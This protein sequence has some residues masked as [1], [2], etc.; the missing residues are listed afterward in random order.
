MN[1]FFRT[2]HLVLG[3]AAG[4]VIALLCFTGAMLAFEKELH[5]LLYPERYYVQESGA[6]R[7]ERAPLDRLAEELRRT[8]P[9]AK[10]ASIK[11]YSDP[12]RTAEVGYGKGRGDNRQAFMNPYSGEVVALGASRAPFFDMMFSLHR[13]LVAGDIGKM[14]VGTSSVIFLFI[15]ATGIVLWWPKSRAILRQ[16]LRLKWDGGW[17]RLTH[18][19]HV[20]IGSYAAI[21]LFICAFTGLAWS[22][23]W[24]NNGI[25]W[26]TGTERPKP[27][28]SKAQKDTTSERKA[29]S[30]DHAYA[31]AQR[32]AP[33][34]LFYSISRPRDAKGA[35][36]V[37]AMP[38][39]AAHEG[40]ATRIYIDQYSGAH[41]KTQ[42][43]ADNNIGQQVRS[44][45]YPVH[46][47][48]IGGLP[49]RIIA[50]LACIAGFTFPFT[51]VIMWLNRLKKKRS[52]KEVKKIE[53][54]TVPAPRR[55]EVLELG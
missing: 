52:L 29:L 39:D 4:L 7:G 46:V 19:L 5:L 8:V 3:L 18:D 53:E 47:G 22:F 13:G 32:E 10:A 9:D 23:E 43:F 6:A 17:R 33:D 12:E 16:R 26:I 45:F 35:M 42:R 37:T 15:L 11:V 24:F 51:G 14:V 48:S 1:R 36:Q 25:Y 31:I 30:F 27:P 20:V 55:E 40:A 21:F 38:R 34:A 49:G 50:M 28:V 2:I 41:I 54:L 44:T